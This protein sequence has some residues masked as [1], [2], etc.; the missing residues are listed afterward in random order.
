MSSFI[1]VDTNI[2]HFA[3]VKPAE[4]EFLDIHRRANEFLLSTLTDEDTRIALSS[5][6]IAEVVEVLRRSRVDLDARM[7]LLADFKTRKFFV[8]DLSLG[9]VEEAIRASSESGIHIYDYLVAYPLK[10]VVG[11]IYSAD[12][13]FQHSHFIKMA[14]VINPLL[15]WILREGIRPRKLKTRQK[16]NP[17]RATTES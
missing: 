3:M 13:H 8:A 4:E 11:R 9:V 12:D 16:W 14:E 1:L 6:Q 5:Y 10:G 2:W 7:R 17:L 15:P